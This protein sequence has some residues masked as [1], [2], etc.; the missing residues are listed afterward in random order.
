MR[1]IF[2]LLLILLLAACQPSAPPSITAILG[3]QFPLAIGQ[4]VTIS[5]AVLSMTLVN[6]SQDARCPALIECAGSG[7]VSVIISVR[8]GAEPAQ[9]LNLQTLTDTL[10]VVS[11]MEFEGMMTRIEVGDYLIEVKE[12]LPYPQ[13]SVSEITPSDYRVSF[14]V[15]GK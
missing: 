6:I 15:T 4:T 3:Q 1:R 7:P 11:V 13:Q 9:E 14:V 10:G 12:V 5:D 8:V 2:L